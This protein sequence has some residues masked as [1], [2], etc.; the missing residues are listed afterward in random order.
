MRDPVLTK[1]VCAGCGKTC[2]GRARQPKELAKTRRWKHGKAK[3]AWICPG[4]WKLM[5]RQSEAQGDVE[6]L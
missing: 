6:K 1:I 4:C 3:G 5:Y 2:R